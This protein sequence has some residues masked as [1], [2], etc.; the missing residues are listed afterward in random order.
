MSGVFLMKRDLP[1]SA[2]SVKK[3]FQKDLSSRFDV[4]VFAVG[5][6]TSPPHHE[7]C[8]SQFPLQFTF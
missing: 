7:V 8:S 5:T 6:A 3:V 1:N 4:G 2:R